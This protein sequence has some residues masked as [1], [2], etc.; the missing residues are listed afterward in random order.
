MDTLNVIDVHPC[1]QGEGRYAGVPHILI[2]TTG[3]NLNC[4]FANSICDTAYASWNPEPGNKTWSDIK[5]VLDENPRI[6]H[7]FITGGEPTIHPVLLADLVELLKQYGHY[8]AI[9][10]NATNYVDIEGINFVTMSPKLLSSTP[11]VANKVDDGG[12]GYIEPGMIVSAVRVNKHARTRQKLHVMSAMMNRYDYQ[13]KFVFTGT[14]DDVQEILW[15]KDHLEIPASRIWMMP[16]GINN[17]QLATKR[18][19]AIAACI[20]W[21]FNYTDRLHIIAYGNT[22]I[23]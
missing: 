20:S 21:G 9:E 4:M 5:H 18:E 2:R 12:M 6:R 17:E 16:E 15:L 13:F 3:C 7:T 11:V 1:I 23:S 8:V 14:S 22:R 19:Q 10:T